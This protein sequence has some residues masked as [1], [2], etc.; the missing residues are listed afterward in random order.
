MDAPGLR[1]FA[2]ITTRERGALLPSYRFEEKLFADTFWLFA[3]EIGVRSVQTDVEGVGA[4]FRMYMSCVAQHLVVVSVP[5]GLPWK[6]C[7]FS[8]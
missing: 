1:G 5:N 7:N 3:T 6:K 2:S 4:W 8:R